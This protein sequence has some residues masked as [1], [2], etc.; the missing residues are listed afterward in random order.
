M[1]C[2]AL[3]INIT[4]GI[5]ELVADG[6]TL[7]M[8]ENFM[9]HLAGRQLIFQGSPRP[10]SSLKRVVKYVARGYNIQ[11]EELVKLAH[12]ISSGIDFNNPAQIAAQVNLN[13]T[14]NTYT[15]TIVPLV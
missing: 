9:E 8:H 4:D 13:G 12:Q 14:I 11:D 7:T 2:C 5:N 10:L 1:C 3:Q 15:R 6:G